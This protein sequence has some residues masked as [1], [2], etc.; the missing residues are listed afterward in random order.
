V[1]EFSFVVP[2]YNSAA[3]IRRCLDSIVDQDFDDYELIVIDDGSVDQTA[4]IVREY[5]DNARVRLIQQSNAGQGAAR[6][7]GVSASQGRYIWFVDSDDW[8]MPGAVYRISKIVEKADAD[9]IL[10]NYLVAYEDGRL[11]PSVNTSPGLLG[12]TIMPTADV[13][14]FAS[15][16]CWN[17][18]PWRLLAKSELLKTHSIKFAEGVFYEDHPFAI[19]L[20]M[21][22]Q[23]MFVDAPASYAYLQRPGSTT[24]TKDVKALDFLKIR[25]TCLD[26]FRRYGKLEDFAA[27]ASTYIAPRD[28]YRAH[29][30]DVDRRKFIDGLA[31]TISA[32]EMEVVRKTGN[33]E[34]ITFAETANAGQVPK[35]AVSASLFRR[36]ATGDGLKLVA[37]RIR[38]VGIRKARGAYN[39]LRG[40]GQ[41]SGTWQGAGGLYN[42]HPVWL[43][44]GVGTHLEPMRIEVRLDKQHR[45]YVTIGDYSLVGGTYVFERGL[46][47]VSIGNKS[48]VGHGTMFIV[49]QDGGI[50]IGNNVMISWDVTLIDSNSHSLDPELRSE[51]A[52]NWLL[53]AASDRIGA[54][55]DW[56]LV[57]SAPITVKDKAWIGFGATI[58]KGVTI[59]EGAVVAARSVVTKDVAPFTIVGGNPARFIGFVPRAKWSW[60]EILLAAHGNP[61]MRQTLDNAYLHHDMASVL[62]RYRRSEEFKATAVLVREFVDAPTALLDVGAGNGICSVAFAM[63][64]FNVTALEPETGRTGGVAGIDAMVEIAADMD[65]SVRERIRVLNIAGEDFKSDT[66]FDIAICRQVVHHFADPV[67][68]LKAVYEALRPGGVVLLIREHVVF[69]DADYQNFLN[70]HPFHRYYKGENAYREHEYIDFLTAA[71]FTFQR[72]LKFKDTPINYEPHSPEI[73]ATLSE[74]DVAGRPYTFVATKPGPA[75]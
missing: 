44:A 42:S 28:F 1:T 69:N 9:V 51:D 34:L 37:A 64:G 31:G 62:Q 49:T 8:L 14:T 23:R 22:T 33:A 21:N 75:I 11:V 48:S 41:S 50:T 71:G 65:P 58:L 67:A 52:F 55:K 15:V 12:R 60:E 70:A 16:S 3:Y 54:Y 68:S 66:P 10:L 32:E 53:C 39:R 19:E 24:Q 56:A 46:G 63:E 36:L 30:S 40:L 35:P 2:A 7:V 17:T 57:E 5:D 26:I 4:D 27:I 59:G 61:D 47:R 25:R 38:S 43:S 74:S 45:P 72:V 20:A 6:N 73:V 29:V 13:N 18:P